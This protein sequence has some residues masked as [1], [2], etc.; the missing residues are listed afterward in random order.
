MPEIPRSSQLPA[1]TCTA[2]FSRDH[3][4]VAATGLSQPSAHRG[5]LRS[6]NRRFRPPPPRLCEPNEVVL[7]LAST[8]TPDLRLV[9]ILT[10]F[11]L[12]LVILG[13]LSLL[14]DEYRWPA[15]V[16]N[17]MGFFFSQPLPTERLS[18]RIWDHT[19]CPTDCSVGLARS[20]L[21]RWPVHRVRGHLIQNIVILLSYR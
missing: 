5:V 21:H 16:R 1:C 4:E 8:Q 11:R 2:F 13:G 3:R 15:P 7:C 18:Q 10:I 12:S 20:G 17:V 6:V 19:A 9:N 14:G